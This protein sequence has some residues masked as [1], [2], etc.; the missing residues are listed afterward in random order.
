MKYCMAKL[1]DS[2]V[3]IALFLEQDTQHAKAKRFFATVSGK[4]Y[5]PTLVLGEV[6]SVLTYKHSKAQAD[7]FVRF[8]VD[9]PELEWVESQ[10]YDDAAYFL[11]IP[12]RLSFIDLSL[13]RLAR[14]LKA[15]LITYDAQLARLYRKTLRRS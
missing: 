2:S 10:A 9:Y 1:I 8:V 5:L 11:T 13:L 6:A 7:M 15:E 14:V 3:W 4:I 12:A